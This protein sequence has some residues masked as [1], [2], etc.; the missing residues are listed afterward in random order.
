MSIGGASGI[1]LETARVLALREAHVI[2]AARNVEAA[3]E[4]KQL[5]LKDQENARIDVLKLDLCSIK[6][7]RAFADSFKALNLPL[8]ILMYVFTFFF[9]LT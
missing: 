6:S 9:L 1:G 7:V 3:N 8:N 2:I 4:A 5:I